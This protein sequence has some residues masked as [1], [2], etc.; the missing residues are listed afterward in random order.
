MATDLMTYARSLGTFL[1][2][3]E[4]TGIEGCFPFVV[5]CNLMFL[6]SVFQHKGDINKGNRNSKSNAIS[7]YH[8]IQKQIQQARS[9]C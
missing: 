3:L 9:N 5:T 6:N 7:Y 1:I 8:Q 2:A 4:P